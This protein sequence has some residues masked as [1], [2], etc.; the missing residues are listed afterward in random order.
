MSGTRV[1]S[2]GQPLKM[3]AGDYGDIFLKVGDEIRPG[4]Y[5]CGIITST[6][7]EVMQRVVINE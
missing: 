7:E 3:G 6:N 4:I 2:S 5:L 1:L